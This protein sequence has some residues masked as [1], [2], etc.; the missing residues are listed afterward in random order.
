MHI[1]D[2][3][4]V[5]LLLLCF[6]PPGAFAGSGGGSAL[7]AWARGEAVVLLRHAL[8]PGAGDPSGFVLD[9]CATQRN[10]SERGR[11]QA[12][13]IGAFLRRYSGEAAVFSSQWCRALETGRLLGLGTVTELPVLNSFFSEPARRE[14]QTEELRDFMRLE[15]RGRPVVL[16]THQLNITALT[17]V[18]PASGELLVVAAGDPETILHRQVP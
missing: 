15:A 4:I 7:A 13:R 10:L 14:A 9:D 11:E 6:S 18:F 2:Q 1:R 8:A 17:G 16:V 5:V 3:L 12:R